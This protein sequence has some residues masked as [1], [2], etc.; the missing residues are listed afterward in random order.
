[1]RL[2]AKPD[3]EKTVEQVTHSIHVMTRNMGARIQ[4]VDPQKG[5]A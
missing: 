3:L 1:M 5:S 4:A 2:Y